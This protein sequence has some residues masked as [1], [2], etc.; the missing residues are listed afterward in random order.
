MRKLRTSRL[1]SNQKVD[2]K[3]TACEEF[4]SK[5][6][7]LKA[8]IRGLVREKYTFTPLAGLI[9]A[10]CGSDTGGSGDSS[11]SSGSNLTGISFPIFG[12]AIKGPLQNAIAFA[13]ED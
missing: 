4:V 13:D 3:E 12:N 7:E 11:S 2:L 8:K 9:L 5:Y 6:D 10:S 1:N